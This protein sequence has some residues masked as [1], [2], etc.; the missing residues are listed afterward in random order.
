MWFPE[1]LTTNLEYSS[2]LTYRML[3]ELNWM[4]TQD[5]LSFG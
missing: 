4:E 2:V 5:D 3:K 1:I